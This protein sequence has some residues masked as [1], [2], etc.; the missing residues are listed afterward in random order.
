MEILKSQ[1]VNLWV[2][3]KLNKHLFDFDGSYIHYNN[4][5]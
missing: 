4:Y 5:T 3:G 1:I 2:E